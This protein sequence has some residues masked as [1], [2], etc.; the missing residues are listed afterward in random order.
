MRTMSFETKFEL[1]KRR[2]NLRLEHL[3][4]F[5]DPRPIIE[6]Y[7]QGNAEIHLHAADTCMVLRDLST[8]TGAGNGVDSLVFVRVV[9]GAQ[10]FRPCASIARLESSDGCLVF[11]AHSTEMESLTGFPPT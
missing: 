9:E 11:G 4:R 1:I 6:R 10:E 8:V 3:K 7:V 2:G 5:D